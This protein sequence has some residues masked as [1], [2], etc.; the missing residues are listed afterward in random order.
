[1]SSS[2]PKRQNV[3]IA[4][5]VHV[6]HLDLD[7]VGD[8]NAAGAM[9]TEDEAH[10]ARRFRNGSDRARW[11]A[12]RAALRRILGDYIGVVPD[13]LRFAYNDYGKPALAESGSDS[14]PLFNM[15]RAGQFALCAV[16]R[17]SALGVDLQG[18]PNGATY[19]S[20]ARNYCVAQ[21][22]RL[23]EQ[24][25][26]AERQSAVCQLWAYKEAY[27]KARGTGLS[28]EI[29]EVVV[30]DFLTGRATLVRASSER[31]P[32]RWHLLELKAYPGHRA[33]LAIVP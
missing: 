6:W 17:C 25:S 23:L 10:R 1:M 4:V 20:L 32:E 14:L 3:T 26:A 11:V 21:E 7:D 24:V 15:S 31:H 13:R 22:Q 28:I 2:I 27:L 19:E 29:D 12:G 30:D 16:A 18:V 5:D 33:A 8:Q 9:L